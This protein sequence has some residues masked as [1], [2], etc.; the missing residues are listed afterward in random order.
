MITRGSYLIIAAFAVSVIFIFATFPVCAFASE[1]HSGI[2]PGHNI[3]TSVPR[4]MSYQG[5]LKDSGGDP[6]VDSVYDVTFRIYDA[7]SGGTSEWSTVL[8][9]TTSAGYFSALF[10]NVNIPFDEDYWLELE[11]DEE[12]LTP[13][14][15]ISM[16]GYSARSD[17]SDY[18]TAGGGWV[19]DGLNVRLEASYDKVGI[20]TSTPTNKLHVTGSESVSTTTR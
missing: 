18:A 5:I 11:V 6:V 19:D 20:G 3:I 2:D 10:D 7:E 12:L 13:R 14:Q 15:K 4:A 8:P 9:C 17:T 16:V 1:T